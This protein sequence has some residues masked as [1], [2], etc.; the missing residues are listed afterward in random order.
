M[1]KNPVAGGVRFRLI[2]ARKPSLKR[3]G[4]STPLLVAGT[5]K[6]LGEKLTMKATRSLLAAMVLATAIGATQANAQCSGTASC[7][8]TNTAS[9]T[10][11]ALVKLAMTSACTTL[12]N[13]TADDVDAGNVIA[14]AGPIFT[15]KANRSWTLKIRSQNATSWTYAGSNS[16]VKPIGDLAW[17]TTS[18][19]TYNAIT[20][21][22]VTFTSGAG[23]TNNGSAQAWFKT[24]WT[25][26]F[27]SASNAPGTYSLPIV[28]TLSAP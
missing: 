22:D 21:A 25:S 14:D 18:G 19:G 17:S 16:G 23:A 1:G 28:F 24:S 9:V 13:P 26:D 5:I 11:G 2:S 4:F 10:V 7:N 20:N 27:T 8:T 15:I 6:F 3:T 12:T